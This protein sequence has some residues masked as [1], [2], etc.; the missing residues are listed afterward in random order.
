MG[1]NR[2][3][4]INIS[5]RQHHSI[6][7]FPWF[8]TIDSRETDFLWRVLICTFVT[9]GMWLL[10]QRVWHFRNSESRFLTRPLIWTSN[11]PLKGQVLMYSLCFFLYTKKKH[12]SKNSTELTSEAIL[13]SLDFLGSWAPVVSRKIEKNIFTYGIKIPSASECAAWMSDPIQRKIH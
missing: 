2:T 10:S 13:M 3:V 8:W 7:G 5:W 12:F 4:N 11:P 9:H 6:Y 1:D